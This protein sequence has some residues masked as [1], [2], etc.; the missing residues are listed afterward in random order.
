MGVWPR[1]NRGLCGSLDR[2]PANEDGCPL[3]VTLLR[4]THIEFRDVDYKVELV[5]QMRLAE[6]V[7]PLTECCAQRAFRLV[8]R[9]GNEMPFD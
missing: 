9:R 5:P 6:L 2:Y 1:E 4:P 8:R 3:V 7:I